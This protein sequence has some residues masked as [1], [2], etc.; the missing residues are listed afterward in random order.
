MIYFIQIENGEK[1]DAPIKI[2]FSDN[3]KTRLMDIQIALPYKINLLA[4]A[5]GDKQ[6]EHLLHQEFAQDRI[7]GE[8]FRPTERLWA[9]IEDIREKQHAHNEDI[10]FSLITRQCLGYSR[11]SASKFPFK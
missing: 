2:G 9:L 8:W 7:R 4:V 5:K 10:K 11:M 6:L 1:S 3:L